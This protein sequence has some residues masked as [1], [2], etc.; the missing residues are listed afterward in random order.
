M[1]PKVRSDRGALPPAVRP[2]LVKIESGVFAIFTW[3]DV[4]VVRWLGERARGPFV[5][6]LADATGPLIA[7]FPRKISVVHM[8]TPRGEL[9]TAEGRAGLTEIMDRDGKHVACVAIILPESGFWASAFQGFITGMHM[10]APRSFA[11]RIESSVAG[12]AQ[13]LPHEHLQRTGTFIN[14]AELAGALNDAWS[15]ALPPA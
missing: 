5:R 2:K 3:N 9:P 6:L 13:W 4:V 12:V 15:W 11:L 8:V 10:V 1:E 7:S 14:P